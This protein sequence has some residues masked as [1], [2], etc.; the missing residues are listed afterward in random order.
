MT[1]PNLRAMIRQQRRQLCATERS[2]L[3][4]QITT[5]LIQLACFSRSQHIALYWP[6]DG[7]V[8]TQGIIQHSWAHNKCCYLPVIDPELKQFTF[9]PY[10]QNTYLQINRYGIMEPP[11]S[12]GIAVQ[13]LDLILL[14]LVAFDANGHRLGTGGGYYDRSLSLLKQPSPLVKPLLIGLAYEFQRVEAL[15]PQPWDINLD[16]IITEQNLYTTSL[17]DIL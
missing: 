4:R 6:F 10:L 17:R 5:Q 14:P 7:E 2:I 1:I 8:E 15:Q 13:N 12:R 11:P 3:S 9:Y 16:R